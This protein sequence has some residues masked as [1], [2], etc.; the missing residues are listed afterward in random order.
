LHRVLNNVFTPARH[1]PW[2]AFKASAA[3]GRRRRREAA[4]RG[5]LKRVATNVVALLPESEPDAL[6]ALCYASELFLA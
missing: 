5:P 2:Q 4:Q 1:W 6:T 3:V